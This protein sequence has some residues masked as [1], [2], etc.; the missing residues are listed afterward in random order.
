MKPIDQYLSDHP[1]IME[2]RFCN[3][4]DDPGRKMT[5][6]QMAVYK[7]R[8]Y[9]VEDK[10]PKTR[11]DYNDYLRGIRLK[12]RQNMTLGHKPLSRQ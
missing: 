10:T 5:A 7:E 1:E 6:K 11:G 12:I 4:N 9:M 8:G 2:I 3:D